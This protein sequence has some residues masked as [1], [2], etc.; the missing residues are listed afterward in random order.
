MQMLSRYRSDLNVRDL[1]IIIL[2]V[3]IEYSYARA[4]QQLV[5]AA[6]IHGQYED[7]T[8]TGLHAMF[9]RIKSDFGMGER[10]YANPNLQGMMQVPM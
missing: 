10:G 1:K 7:I 9:R 3:D 4:L 6:G 5:S 2:G 8:H